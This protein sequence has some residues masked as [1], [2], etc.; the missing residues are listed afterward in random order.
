MAF[1][2][3][4][5]RYHR[6]QPPPPLPQPPPSPA[7]TVSHHH[8]RHRHCHGHPQ[9]SHHRPAATVASQRRQTPA[10]QIRPGW[11]GSEVQC[12][13]RVAGIMEEG[14]T[15]TAFTAVALTRASR[16]PRGG[17]VLDE[18]RRHGTRRSALPSSPTSSPPYPPPSP[19]LA[20]P[21]PGPWSGAGVDR[22]HRRSPRPSGESRSGDA[23]ARR[24]SRGEPTLSAPPPCRR[25]AVPVAMTSP[26][27]RH[28]RHACAG[29]RWSRGGWPRHRHPSTSPGFAGDELRWLRS[30][31]EGG[32]GVAAE[33]RVPPPR[34]GLI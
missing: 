32:G 15:G 6:R 26:S 8:H 19:P 33:A 10:I 25:H 11:R 20:T 14:V 12:E 23:V 7:A 22:A 5:H 29:A 28:R 4:C 34:G 13:A 27:R 18:G 24:W 31:E 9:S 3:R 21:L 30:M 16:L 1:N 2:H 17:E